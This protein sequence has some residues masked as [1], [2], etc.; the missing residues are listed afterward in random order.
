MPNIIT[1]F[2]TIGL[3][4]K[5]MY[6]V[7]RI[8]SPRLLNFEYVKTVLNSLLNLSLTTNEVINIVQLITSYPV[9]YGYDVISHFRQ[10]DTALTT[11]NSLSIVIDVKIS[12]C[13]ICKLIETLETYTPQLSKEPIMYGLRGVEV[14]SINIKRCKACL[15]IHYYSF[16]IHPD[17]KLKHFYLDCHKSEYYQYTS[18]TVFE[19]HLLNA[20]MADIMIKHSNFRNF[21]GAYNYLHGYY[22]YKKDSCRKA[23][24]YKRLIEV[25]FSWK[26]NQFYSEV[27]HQDLIIQNIQSQV[28]PIDIILQE[29]KKNLQTHFMQK[30]TAHK[31]EGDKTCMTAIVMDGLWKVSRQK[32][33]YEHV[34][35]QTKEFG[36]IQTGCQAS[37]AYGSYYCQKHQ[38]A[39]LTIRVGSKA[40]Q[41]KPQ[42]INIGRLTRREVVTEIYD[43]F[44]T[45][46]EQELFFCKGNTFNYRWLTEHDLQKNLLQQFR[47]IKK[48]SLGDQHCNTDKSIQYTCEI[49]VRTRGIETLC[50]NCG[51]ILAFKEIYGS[52]SLTQGAL[53]YLELF[54]NFKGTNFPKYFVYDNA[55]NMMKFCQTR[56]QTSDR[57]NILGKIK[58][59]VDKLHIKGHVGE[60]CHSHCHPDLFPELKELNTVVCEQKNFWLG[61]YKYSLKHMNSYRY[62]FFLYIICD[63][64]NNLNI[65]NSTEILSRELEPNLYAEKKL[66]DQK[67]KRKRTI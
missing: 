41:I 16:A 23:L 34:M 32:C 30:W 55:C 60:F 24:C 50:S 61:R 21:S 56:T 4:T 48:A 26:L 27:M 64:Y 25:F 49:K 57:A 39:S 33:A 44:V 10:I 58:Y 3:Q 43:S 54:Q 36:D 12:S 28:N 62:N 18:E 9:E 15:S 8:Y 40:M 17:T 11:S 47:D 5:A 46:S 65:T 52:E 66:D 20:L 6:I 7:R 45:V 35:V 42:N 31:H 67:K 29:L 37:P 63:E 51:T 2:P 59:V 19:R 13:Y 1:P 22:A 38:A 53:L 14:C